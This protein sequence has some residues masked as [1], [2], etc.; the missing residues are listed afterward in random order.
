MKIPRGMKMGTQ[1][2][3]AWRWVLLR[4]LRGRRAR[5]LVTVWEGGKC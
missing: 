1:R 3:S 4:V 2:C 5:R